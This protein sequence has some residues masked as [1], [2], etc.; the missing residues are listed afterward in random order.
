MTDLD[1]LHAHQ[2]EH[3][4]IA[5]GVL[6]TFAQQADVPYSIVRD[7]FIEGEPD[8]TALFWMRVH[9]QHP[10]R[11]VGVSWCHCCRKF[12]LEEIIH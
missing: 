9:E 8:T 6:R 7:L 1:A 11:F 4:R 3:H 12:N 10:G 2:K 5:S